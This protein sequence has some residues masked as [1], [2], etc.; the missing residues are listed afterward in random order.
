MAEL[1]VGVRLRLL[2]LALEEVVVLGVPPAWT[3]NQSELAKV[4][5]A[6]SI[7]SR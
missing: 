4:R 5:S 2:R 3:R 7:E 1:P 6:A